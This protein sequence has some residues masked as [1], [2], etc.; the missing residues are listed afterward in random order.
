MKKIP[1]L[2]QAQQEEKKKEKSDE[3]ERVKKGRQEEIQRAEDDKVAR[4]KEEQ[5]EWKRREE[6]V[7]L[8]KGQ[9]ETTVAKR[10]K[11]EAPNY[12]KQLLSFQKQGI[13]PPTK[14]QQFA[15]ALQDPN[16]CDKMAERISK[17]QAARYIYILLY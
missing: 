1:R 5:Q 13:A 3:E 17:S 6:K 10:Q 15:A 16:E 7:K 14:K 9:K 4:R 11:I 12:A 2:S 8:K